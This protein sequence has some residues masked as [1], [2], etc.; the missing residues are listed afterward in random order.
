MQKMQKK[1]AIKGFSCYTAL[2]FAAGRRAFLSRA[3]FLLHTMEGCFIG[4]FWE[5]F[6]ALCKVLHK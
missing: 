6:S 2:R 5:V 3:V 1:L 4:W